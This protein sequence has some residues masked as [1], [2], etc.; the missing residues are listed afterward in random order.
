[1][2]LLDMLPGDTMPAHQLLRRYLE[3]IPHTRM[4]CDFGEGNVI[5]WG[6]CSG[7]HSGAYEKALDRVREWLQ[8]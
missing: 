6:T 4:V 3:R 2:R 5:D 1:M 7:S 8:A